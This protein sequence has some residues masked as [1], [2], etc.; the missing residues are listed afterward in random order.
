MRTQCYHSYLTLIEKLPEKTQV[1][2]GRGWRVTSLFIEAFLN[3][4]IQFQIKA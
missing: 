3:K 2:T 1:I 4:C